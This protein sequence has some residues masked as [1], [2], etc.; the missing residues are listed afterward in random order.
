MAR[1]G[2][3]TRLFHR[4]VVL[5]HEIE[6]EEGVVLCPH[7][8]VS[9]NNHLGRGVAVNIHSSVD[10]DARIGEWS[11]INCHCDLT[12][13]VEIG[14]EVWLSSRVSVAPGV[15]IG[16]SAYIGAGSVVMRDVEPRT[17]VFGVPARR[18]E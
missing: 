7:V 13:G 11:Q 3:F 15:K 5:G 8:V 6:C 18:I 14:R 4:T 17:K 9:A 10:H 1:G 2:L 12:G 16:D